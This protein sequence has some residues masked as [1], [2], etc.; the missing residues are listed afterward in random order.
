MGLSRSLPDVDVE[1]VDGAAE[2]AAAGADAT[3][4]DAELLSAADA[5][6]DTP[7]PPSADAQPDTPP[8]PSADAQPDTPS[9]PSVDDGPSPVDDGASPERAA[10]V[11]AAG[12]QALAGGVR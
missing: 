7:S 2:P 12:T 5:Q 10:M 11:E 6:P 9:P 3:E 1:E 4:D 8:P